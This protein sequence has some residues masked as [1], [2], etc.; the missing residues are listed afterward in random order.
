MVLSVWMI[1][2]DGIGVRGISPSGFRS[3]KPVQDWAISKVM[4][5][6]RLLTRILFETGSKSNTPHWEITAM[7]PLPRR[8][9]SF[10]EF[11]PLR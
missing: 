10:R 9:A 7:G 11:H 6:W 4:P 3:S 2:G 8:P 1:S 5:G